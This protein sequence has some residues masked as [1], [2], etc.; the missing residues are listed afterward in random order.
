[1]TRSVLTERML[2]KDLSDAR[3]QWL[4]EV[5]DEPAELEKRTQSDFLAAT[6]HAGE[7]LDFHSLRHTCG[8]WLAMTGCHPKEEQ[9]VM[10]HQ[11]ITLSMD[12]YGHLLP[13]QEAESVNKLPDVLKAP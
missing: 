9:A 8:A 5:S 4:A 2:R 7:T 3:K 13:G 12:T 1:M 6:N 11:S 10:R